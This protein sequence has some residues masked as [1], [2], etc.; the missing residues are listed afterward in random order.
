MK[1]KE[2]LKPNLKKFIIFLVL[3][4]FLGL[5]FLFDIFSLAQCIAPRC[6]NPIKL[7]WWKCA[8]CR[9]ITWRDYLFGAIKYL[10]SPSNFFWDFY[11]IFDFFIVSLIYYWLISCLISQVRI[12]KRDEQNKVTTAF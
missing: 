1:P 3:F 11:R 8:T 12:S 2:F 7:P 10:I 5:P 9:E 4:F 6:T